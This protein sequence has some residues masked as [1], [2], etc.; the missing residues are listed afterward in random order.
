[1]TFP[2]VSC[3]RKLATAVCVIKCSRLPAR[4]PPQTASAKAVVTINDAEKLKRTNQYVTSGTPWPAHE[5]GY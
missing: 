1:M 2:V 4:H 5:L 3:D